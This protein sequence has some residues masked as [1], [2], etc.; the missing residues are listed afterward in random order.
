M[1]SL[2]CPSFSWRS[3]PHG[4]DVLLLILQSPPSR[5]LLSAFKQEGSTKVS[6]TRLKPDET[7]AML[8]EDGDETRLGGISIQIIA[9]VTQ[10]QHHHPT[11]EEGAP[12]SLTAPKKPFAAGTVVL[13]GGGVTPSLKRRAFKPFVSKL[14]PQPRIVLRNNDDSPAPSQA[15]EN[16][17]PNTSTTL[18]SPSGSQQTAAAAGPRK[19]AGLGGSGRGAGAARRF[20]A[21]RSSG[22][23][24]APSDTGVD[25]ARSGMG[26]TRPS[27]VSGALS[28]TPAWQVSDRPGVRGTVAITGGSPFVTG[29]NCDSSVAGRSAAAPES[30]SRRGPDSVE[31]PEDIVLEWTA[32]DS[33]QPLRVGASLARRLHPHQREGLKVLWECMAGRGG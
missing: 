8:Q 1:D 20:H 12:S 17:H 31:N 11:V 32:G 19:R 30:S 25:A 4:I 10:E 15:T 23:L 33:P 26:T 14:T 16:I 24:V 21:P 9:N 22:V 7:T 6:S 5:L 3:K 28:T 27:P 29:V 13:S 2:L 18:G